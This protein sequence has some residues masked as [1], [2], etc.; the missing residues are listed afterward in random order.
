LKD[1]AL[2]PLGLTASEK[3]S[4]KEF[5]LSLS[6]DPISIPMPKGV[7]VKY[8]PIPDWKSK[9]NGLDY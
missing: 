2:K 8:D 4:L 5:L 7:T 1:S 6:G 3:E 9:K